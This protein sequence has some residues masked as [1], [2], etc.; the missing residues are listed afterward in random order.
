MADTPTAA[1]QA[2]QAAARAEEIRRKTAAELQRH[3]QAM[4]AL[5]RPRTR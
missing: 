1:Q 4:A 3:G 2:A 5:T